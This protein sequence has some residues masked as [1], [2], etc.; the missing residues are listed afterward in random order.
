M[1]PKIFPHLI[2]LNVNL[3]WL[4]FGKGEMFTDG[5]KTLVNIADPTGTLSEA[6]KL[7]SALPEEKQIECIGY[8][9]DKKLLLE[10]Q[11]KLRKDATF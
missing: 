9:K 11:E 1:P 2:E 8:I 4:L 6:V 5:K 7:L 10:L 3:N